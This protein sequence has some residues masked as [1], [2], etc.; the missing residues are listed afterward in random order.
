MKH[1]SDSSH[2]PGSLPHTVNPK[3]IVFIHPHP[4]SKPQTRGMRKVSRGG[5]W[6]LVSRVAS[7]AAF[8]AF[9]TYWDS[10]F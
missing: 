4:N 8:R 2:R 3:P 6:D 10:G 9:Q 5:P 7:L 1:A